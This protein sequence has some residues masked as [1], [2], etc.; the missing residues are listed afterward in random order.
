MCYGVC[1][2]VHMQIGNLRAYARVA[3]VIRCVYIHTYIHT[4]IERE[5]CARMHA[6]ACVIRCVYIHTYIYRERNLRAY[7]RVGLCDSL[8]WCYVHELCIRVYVLCIYV[9]VLCIRMYVLCVDDKK[10]L[11]Y[12]LCPRLIKQLS[13]NTYACRPIIHI[14]RTCIHT[15]ALN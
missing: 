5:I 13:V 2:W 10:K 11:C 14:A 6:L 8:C 15:Y 3:C 4:Y 12:A 1:V 9:Y 7:A